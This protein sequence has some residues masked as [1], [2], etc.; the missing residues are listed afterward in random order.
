MS[1]I[2]LTAHER[3]VTSI[4]AMLACEWF[5]EQ[6]KGNLIAL[7]AD[8]L[9]RCRS[10]YPLG[11]L[12]TACH[13]LLRAKTHMEWLYA[14]DAIARAVVPVLRLDVVVREPVGSR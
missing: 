8:G 9:P 12:V 5:H 4:C 1:R 11:D 6:E 3:S 10:V 2:T 7:L 13:I 14:R